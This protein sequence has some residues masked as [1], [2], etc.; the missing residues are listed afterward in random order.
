[1]ERPKRKRSAKDKET[2]GANLHRCRLIFSEYK[3]HVIEST[4]D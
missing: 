1:M 4:Q 2:V 3:I